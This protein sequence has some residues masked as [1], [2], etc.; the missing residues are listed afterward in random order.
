MWTVSAGDDVVAHF[1][2]ALLGGALVCGGLAAMTAELAPD[3]PSS[4]LFAVATSGA[5]A[6]ATAP[7]VLGPF[8]GILAAGTLAFAAA[9]IGPSAVSAEPAP[10][11]EPVRNLPSAIEDAPSAPLYSRRLASASSMIGMPSRT[12]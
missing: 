9:F 8:R 7:L 10:L 4:T 5:L 2:V 12:G 11:R 6:G 3:L 1:S